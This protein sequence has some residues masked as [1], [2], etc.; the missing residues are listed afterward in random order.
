MP[1]TIE[2]RRAKDA[3]RKRAKRAQKNLLSSPSNPNPLNGNN[4]NDHPIILPVADEAVTS[5]RPIGRYEKQYQKLLDDYLGP[6]TGILIL[7]LCLFWFRFSMEQSE[8]IA[9]HLAMNQDEQ[10]LVIP[11]LASWMDKQH[12][13][14]AARDKILQSGDLIGLA[15]GFGSYGARVLG[16][17]QE[18]RKGRYEQQSRGQT[19]GQTSNNGHN[20]IQW[21]NSL[22]GL[23]QYAAN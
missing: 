13:D 15:L 23:S 19:P 22:A 2:E 4:Q 7:L 11:P 5:P 16:T 6:T 9:D 10:A 14:V 3:A 17:L 20:A 18:L 8:Q 12:W 21:G 1:Q